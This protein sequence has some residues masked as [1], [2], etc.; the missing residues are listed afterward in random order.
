MLFPNEKAVRCGVPPERVMLQFKGITM[1]LC[2]LQI[3]QVLEILLESELNSNNRY[4]SFIDKEDKTEKTLLHYA[5]ELGFF[6]VTKT[7]V[8]KCPSLL[9]VFTKSQLKPKKRAMLPV[10]FAL[11]RESDEVAAYLIRMMRHERYTVVCNVY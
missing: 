5:A 1:L 10:E 3:N 9:A 6:H 4:E 11:M 8:K 7:L 2:V